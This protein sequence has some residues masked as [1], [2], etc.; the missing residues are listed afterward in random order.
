MRYRTLS[1]SVT[2][3]LDENIFYCI[4]RQIIH[5]NDV[6]NR[7]K[8]IQKEPL[9]SVIKPSKDGTIKCVNKYTNI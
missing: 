8:T 1:I 9:R 3:T 4:G 6:K 7:G 2:Y 5:T